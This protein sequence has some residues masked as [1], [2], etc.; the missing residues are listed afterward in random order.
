[1]WFTVKQ[2]VA[3]TLNWVKCYQELYVYNAY[4]YVYLYV[5]DVYT[6]VYDVYVYLYIVYIYI[7]ICT[8]V[9]SKC[10]CIYVYYDFYTFINVVVYDV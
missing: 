1:M 5:Y 7:F 3:L 10:G 6:Y 2:S 9:C 4:V 8:C